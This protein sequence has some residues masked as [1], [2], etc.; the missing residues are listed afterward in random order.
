[1]TDPDQGNTVSDAT[2]AQGDIIYVLN[3]LNP[4]NPPGP[5][6]SEK[7]N[8][9]WDR[10]NTYV[11]RFLEARAET[12]DRVFILIAYLYW[13][14]EI[15]AQQKKQRN[16]FKDH[17]A[18]ELIM[19]NDLQIIDATTISNKAEIYHWDETNDDL[20]S[21]APERFWRQRFDKSNFDKKH[22]SSTAL[23]PLRKFCRCERPYNPDRTMYQHSSGCKGWNHE[24]CLIDEVG[25]R[26]WQS[27][28]S[29]NMDDYARYNTP[30]A[31]KSLAQVVKN[32][33]KKLEGRFENIIEQGVMAVQEEST[34]T[35]HASSS[36]NGHNSTL[37]PPAKTPPSKSHKKARPKKKNLWIKNLTISIIANRKDQ[38]LFAEVKE[39]LSDKSWQVKVDCLCCDKTLD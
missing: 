33:G 14:E 32:M 16:F 21:E 17:A 23:S 2:F 20:V 4:P 11:A 38:P 19:S 27:Y 31:S 10:K 9:E 15:P 28:A 30:P 26:L 36:T 25:A 6:A 3:R 18:G 24:E 12:P 5:G 7:E 8:L 37:G 29:G 22:D 35:L 39:K 1:M 34:A 13:P